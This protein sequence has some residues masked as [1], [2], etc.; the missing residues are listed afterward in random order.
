MVQY[1]RKQQNEQN[2]QDEDEVA[3]ESNRSLYAQAVPVLGA[4]SAHHES[5]KP[6]KKR[7]AVPRA[8]HHQISIV[9]L[10]PLRSNGIKTAYTEIDMLHVRL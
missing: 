6:I 10:E 2:E 4:S 9:R 3:V 8:H 1:I 7:W 5:L